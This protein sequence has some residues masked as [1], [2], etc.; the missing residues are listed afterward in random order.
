MIFAEV[1]TLNFSEEDYVNRWYRG[2]E[3]RGKNIMAGRGSPAIVQK[4]ENGIGYFRG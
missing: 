3:L 1:S 4:G 2:G